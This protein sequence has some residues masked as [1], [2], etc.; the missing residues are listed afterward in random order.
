MCRARGPPE[1][2]ADRG[3]EQ[4]ENLTSALAREIFGLAQLKTQNPKLK[5]QNPLSMTP[6]EADHYE[7]AL[8]RILEVEETRALDLSLNGLFELPELSPELERLTSLKARS[9]LVLWAQQFGT[10]SKLTASRRWSWRSPRPVPAGKPHLPK[11]RARSLRSQRPVPLANLTCCK[12]S[13]STMRGL[14]GDLFPLARLTGWKA[15]PL[16]MRAPQCDCP[17]WKT[18]RAPNLHLQMPR[19]KGHLSPL[20][21]LTD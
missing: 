13:T 9:F 16:W 18:H 15:P 6:E 8:R 11:P 7:E 17:H 4:R 1:L 19:P 20:A 3:T 10:A 2:A 5:T 21:K 14:R 12:R